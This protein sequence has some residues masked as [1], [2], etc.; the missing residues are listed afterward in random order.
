[1]SSA[2]EMRKLMEGVITE[3]S[4]SMK[5]VLNALQDLLDSTSLQAYAEHQHTAQLKA[6]KILDSFGIKSSMREEWPNDPMADPDDFGVQDDITSDPR[7]HLP[8]EISYTVKYSEGDE[9]YDEPDSYT[10]WRK[11]GG[12]TTA[13]THEA[14][15]DVEA[16]A[17]IKADAKKSGIGGKYNV[18]YM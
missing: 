2:S 6:Q 17:I 11:E 13:L 16:E 10:V 18:D 8:T 1:M 3:E 15:T 5:D 14:R 7:H 4:F 9:M 12:A